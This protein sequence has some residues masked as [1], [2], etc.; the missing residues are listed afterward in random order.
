MCSSHAARGVLL[1]YKSDRV[2]DLTGFLFLLNK[3]QTRVKEIPWNAFSSSSREPHTSPDLV[4][5]C[6]LAIYFSSHAMLPTMT[7]FARQKNCYVF[8]SPVYCPP[9]HKAGSS[10]VRRD[11][12]FEFQSKEYECKWHIPSP[13]LAPKCPR[14]VF[15]LLLAVCRGYNGQLQ[16]DLADGRAP[17]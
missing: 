12:I 16:G 10:E 6:H 7:C 13:G 4:T 1:R 2:I 17:N 8:S 15:S 3:I 11:H 9:L 14:S 5:L